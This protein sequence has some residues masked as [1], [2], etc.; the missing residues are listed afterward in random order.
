MNA[1]LSLEGQIAVVT[2]GTGGIGEAICL[3]LASYGANVVVVYNK[4]FEKADTL[5]KKIKCLSQESISIK[6]DITVAQD[7]DDMVLMTTKEFGAIDILVNSA[8]I[9]AIAMPVV[10]IHERDWDHVLNVNLKGSYLCC[11]AVA[12]EMIKQ[13]KGKIINIS[14]IFGEHSPALRGAYGASKHGVIGLTQTLAK[15]LGPYN[16]TVNAICP[17]PVETELV[18]D[19]Y[20]KSARTLGMSYEEYYK[21]VVSSIPLGRLAKPDEVANLVAFIASDMANYITGSVIEIAGGAT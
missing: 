18:K 8:G 1:V 7:V 10:E 3:K 13:R 14:S 21:T 12:K 16:I 6:A 9:T 15:E 2:G 20:E 5:A 11:K 17:G 4:R 19:I